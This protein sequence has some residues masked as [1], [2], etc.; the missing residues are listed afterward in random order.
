M[1]WLIKRILLSSLKEYRKRLMY[2]QVYKK[3]SF[4]S[5]THYL[6]LILQVRIKKIKK[7]SVVVSKLVLIS[8]KVEILGGLRWGIYPSLKR[9]SDP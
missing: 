1:I 8:C 5:K 2:L 4:K 6:M 9:L 7:L 3:C